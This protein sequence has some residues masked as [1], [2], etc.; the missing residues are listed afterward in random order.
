MLGDVVTIGMGTEGSL[1]PFL[2]SF[3]S[4]YFKI[5]YLGIGLG[6]LVALAGL[7]V[8]RQRELRSAMV[9]AMLGTATIYVATTSLLPSLTYVEMWAVQ[10][11]FRINIFQ[12]YQN[13]YSDAFA[14]SMPKRNDEQSCQITNHKR[15]NIIMVVVE[16]LSSY[17]S[18]LFS[19]INDF[20]PGIDRLAKH[21]LYFTNFHA[22]GFSTDGGLTALLT[23]AP[24]IPAPGRFNSTG[25]GF[26][27]AFNAA[28]SVPRAYAEAGFDT[29]FLTSGTLQFA[30]QGDWLASIGFGILESGEHPAYDGLPRFSFNSVTD[31]ALYTRARQWI[32]ERRGRPFFLVLE[33]VTTHPPFIDPDTKAWSMAGAFRHADQALED[34]VE[35]LRGSGYFD[36]GLVIIT[37]DHRAMTPISFEEN[38][39]FGASAGHRLP[40]IVLGGRRGQV[41]VALQQTDLA[42]SLVAMASGRRC[43]NLWRGDALANPPQAARCIVRVRG[44]A[45][46]LIDADCDG[47]EAVIRLDGDDTALLDGADPD[48]INAV[49]RVRLDAVTAETR[50]A[51]ARR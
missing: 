31:R 46:D 1:G 45:R 14:A 23:G 48:L 6:A 2:K 25:L 8:C 39:M 4:H 43:S 3:F 5:L 42:G 26:Y 22:N 11:T 18:E 49:N 47:R 51:A 19:G 12:T 7:L 29:G 38:K 30:R 34:L 15:Q 32:Q 10:N 9:G 37:G 41:D 44:D 27:G 16:S 35:D 24:P 50:L 33:T 40:L 20:T 28:F 17:Q 21:G 13:S 36:N